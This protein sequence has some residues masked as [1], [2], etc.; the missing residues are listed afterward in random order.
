MISRSK[1]GAGRTITAIRFG[2]LVVLLCVQIDVATAQDVVASR[3]IRNFDLVLLDEVPPALQRK[4]VV[5]VGRISLPADIFTEP[6]PAGEPVAISI[7]Y[8]R[9]VDLVETSRRTTRD[10]KTIVV[11]V[12][13][14]ELFSQ[15]TM[16]LQDNVLDRGD[17]RLRDVVVKITAPEPIDGV[18]LFWLQAIDPR[19]FPDEKAPLDTD[20]EP[21]NTTG[22]RGTTSNE[23]TD[24]SNDTSGYLSDTDGEQDVAPPL[25]PV[26]VDVLVIYTPRAKLESEKSVPN[27]GLG[28]SIDKTIGDAIDHA[29]TGLVAQANVM[30]NLVGKE[31]VQYTEATNMKEDVIR[32]ACPC[33]HRL[34]SVGS[35]NLNEVF[36]LWEDTGAD[37][38][39][40]WIDSPTG[41]AGISFDPIMAASDVAKRSVSVVDWF[42][43]VFG[44]SF[45]HEIGHNFYAL[46]DRAQ[47]NDGE[48]PWNYNYGFGNLDFA[49]V[50]IMAYKSTCDS[51]GVDCTRVGYWSDPTVAPA[52]SLGLAA[53]PHAAH[54]ARTLNEKAGLISALSTKQDMVGCCN[55][56]GNIFNRKYAPGPCP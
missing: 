25:L 52:N 39:S 26:V 4:N 46:H 45:D 7:D 31:M 13:K 3:A 19:T 9:S 20:V 32:L 6:P 38:V 33:D 11:G 23:Q 56:Y 37:L 2:V 16:F 36:S 54:N 42:Y 17:I 8:G 22:G 15:F 48:L 28:Q 40:L 34:K 47:E 35:N 12:V 10:G 1:R 29:N 5:R 18:L 51:F 43:A 24:Q 21:A 27:G 41:E 14:G 50:T 53:G 44:Y 55:S 30:L 49:V